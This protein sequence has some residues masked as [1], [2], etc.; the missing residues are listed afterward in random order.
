[1]NSKRNVKGGK[2]FKKGSNKNGT[3]QTFRSNKL[4]LS[5]DED[6]IYGI[7][8]K[9]LGN[10]QFIIKCVDNKEKRCVVGGK[11]SGKQKQNNIVK[12]G[13]WLLVGKRSWETTRPGKLETCDLLYIYSEN[14]KKSVQ[15]QS[16]NINFTP[17]LNEEQMLNN[18][19]ISENTFDIENNI[20]IQ[21]EENITSENIVIENQ[22]QPI[23]EIID[24]DEI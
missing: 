2:K 14:E 22:E 13:M 23:E 3:S 15:S 20:I 19:Y 9:Q 5:G 17:L 21:S 4:V 8:T 18:N 11:F 12:I 24:F 16:S 7:V 10:G 6:E 1:M